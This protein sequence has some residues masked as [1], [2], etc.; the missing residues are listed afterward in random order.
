MVDE[1]QKLII[2]EFKEVSSWEERYKKIMD[3]GKL[4]PPMDP[5]H[6]TE[7]NKVR[8][9]QSQ[10]WMFAELDDEGKMVLFVDSDAMIVRGLAA[11]FARV[12]T[13]EKPQD[14]IYADFYFIKEIGLD[15]NLSQTRVGGL[16]AMI[17]QI[18]M[19]ALAYTYK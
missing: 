19:Y 11:L 3:I 18:K 7:E 1:K 14:L 15:I 17:K 8:G 13:G 4:L 16:A 9:C 10:L 6:Q 5:K 12:C 2:R